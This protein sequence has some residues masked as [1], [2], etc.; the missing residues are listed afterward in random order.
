MTKWVL[1]IL[2]HMPQPLEDDGTGEGYVQ[3]KDIE[4]IPATEE[5]S[6]QYSC[7]MRFLSVSEYEFLKA[8]QHI[9]DGGKEV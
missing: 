5:M 6:E 7:Q 2:D 9:M 3:R 1:E 4:I 8:I